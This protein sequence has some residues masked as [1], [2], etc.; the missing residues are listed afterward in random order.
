MMA[1]LHGIE[2]TAPEDETEKVVD[3]SP[4]LITPSKEKW[5]NGVD[6]DDPYPKLKLIPMEHLDSSSEE[7]F[8]DTECAAE[9][10]EDEG[11]N[12]EVPETVHILSAIDKL[13]VDRAVCETESIDYVAKSVVIGVLENVW[14]EACV[15]NDGGEGCKTPEIQSSALNPDSPIFMP[16]LKT[17]IDKLSLNPS[18]PEFKP[19]VSQPPVTDAKP[20]EKLTENNTNVSVP[21]SPHSKITV[22]G[23]K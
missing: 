11:K 10:Q 15:E 4:V 13:K 14:K 16:S 12:R 22:Q 3:T 18:S 20:A 8:S 1:S 23:Q 7:E 6:T 2:V 9:L 5:S 17:Q 19:F 21:S